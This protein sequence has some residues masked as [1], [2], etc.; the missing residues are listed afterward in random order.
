[1]ATTLGELL[2]VLCLVLVLTLMSAL[3]LVS[4]V[5]DGTNINIMCL[6]YA[7]GELL[8]ILLRELWGGRCGNQ[9]R[10]ASLLTA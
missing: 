8:L 6:P 3:A 4:G 9:S 5:G 1:M 7:V 2:G 10:R